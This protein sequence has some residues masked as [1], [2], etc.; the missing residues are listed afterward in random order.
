MKLLVGRQF[1]HP[2]VQAELKNQPFQGVALPSGGVGVKIQ[3]DGEELVISAEHCMA[4]CLVKA[5]QIASRANANVG[6]GDCV[7]AVPASYTDLQ[8]RGILHACE[9]ASLNCLKITNENNAVALSYGIFKSAKK[10]FSETDKENYM[11]IDLGYSA[12]CVTIA[13]FKQGNMSILATVCDQ[14]VGGRSYDDAIVEYLCEVFEKKTKIN[15]RNNLKARLKLQVAAEKAKKTLSPNGVTEAPISVEC[16]A[17]D[18]D[19]NCMVSKDEFNER[20]KEINDRLTGPVLQALKEAG[21]EAKDLKETEIVGGGSRVGMVKCVIGAALGLDPDAM[22]NGLKTTMNSDEAVAR[23]NALQCAMLSSRVRVQP[24]TIT[25]KLYYG[26]VATYDATSTGLS[27][28]NKEEE[29][30]SSSA[31]LYNRGDDIPHKPRRLTFRKKAADFHVTL[32]YDSTMPYQEH[33]FIAKYLIKVPQGTSAQDV[34]V[35]FNIDKHGCVYLQCAEMLEEIAAAAEEAKPDEAAPAPD[36]ADAKAEGD[37]KEADAAKSGDEKSA[38][39]APAKK[40]FKKTDLATVIETFG[41]TRNDIKKALELEAS[42]AF[43]DRLIVETSDKRNELESYIYAMRAKIN[44]DLK[45]YIQ[46]EEKTQLTALLTDAEDWLDND[47]YE[48]TKSKYAAKLE[49]M[50]KISD[51]VG[52][53]ITEE[54]NR[55][56]AIESL[57]KQIE[58]CKSFAANYDEKYKHIDETDR[59]KI[60]SE[61]SSAEEWMYDMIGKQGD[62]KQ[63]KDPV[64][65]VDSIQKKK[66]ALFQV[67]NPIMIKRAPAPAPAR[68]PAEG[69]DSEPVEGKDAAGDSEGDSKG[70][71]KDAGDEAPDTDAPAAEGEGM[72][73]SV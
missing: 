12:Y 58:M 60:R 59:D 18:I 54:M 73:T 35:T 67:T 8:R 49:E 39:A 16:L 47:G 64:F 33:R 51:K 68:A 10:L 20:T 7:L 25:D 69:K 72:D 3:Y 40:R 13:S 36:A 22:N 23:G 19:L 4:M 62:L 38:D 29:L 63:N 43:E 30:K 9:I 28:E 27:D 5:M 21:L 41:L 42:M 37:S 53:R 52:L 24:F 45:N 71:S 2:E 6:I 46:P 26:I 55:P 56:G 48:A 65:T 44:A 15:V 34:R 32:S 66:T 17:E 50:I 61:S 57:K 14:N 1:D 31:Q 11:F 70:E